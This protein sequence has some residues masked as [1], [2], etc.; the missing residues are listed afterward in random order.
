MSGGAFDY[1]YCKV[2][3]FADDL[4]QRLDTHDENDDSGNTPNEFS[5]HVLKKLKEIEIE[6]RKAAA[7]MREAEWL[8]S[9]DTGE[10][11]FMRRVEAIEAGD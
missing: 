4:A 3:V 11:A 1:A 2:V 10:S 6:C 8:Y 9:G 5:Q 7:L